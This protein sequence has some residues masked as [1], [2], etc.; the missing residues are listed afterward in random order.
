MNV[1]VM[2]VCAPDGGRRVCFDRD[3]ADD[4]DDA[5][6]LMV[7]AFARCLAPNGMTQ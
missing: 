5:G 1:S 6:M 4:A 7:R 3:D 2:I